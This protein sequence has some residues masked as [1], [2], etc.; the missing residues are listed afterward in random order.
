MLSGGVDSEIGHGHE[1]GH[2]GDVD[3]GTLAPLGHVWEE[4]VTEHR[5]G[6]HVHCDDFL[7][8]PNPYIGKETQIFLS[9][10][11]R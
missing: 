1:A 10:S 3:D 6:Q 2:R 7:T 8:N 5:Q 4:G 9:S 11:S